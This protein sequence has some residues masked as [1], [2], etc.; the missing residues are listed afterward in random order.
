MVFVHPLTDTHADHEVDA[1]LAALVR[2]VDETAAEYSTRPDAKPAAADWLG[3][4]R[5]ALT[6]CRRELGRGRRA[7]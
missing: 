7:G 2:D 1:R 5:Y 3:L 6:R 4:A